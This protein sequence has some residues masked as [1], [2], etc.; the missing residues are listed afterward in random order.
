M[1]ILRRMVS[2]LVAVSNPKKKTVSQMFGHVHIKLSSNDWSSRIHFDR[3]T[4]FSLSCA[5]LLGHKRSAPSFQ[6]NVNARNKVRKKVS[7]SCFEQLKFQE[8]MH[9]RLPRHL[10]QLCA[11]VAQDLTRRTPMGCCA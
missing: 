7:L 11:E 8:E 1:L 9:V 6:H 4:M 5:T 3:C 10:M 2:E